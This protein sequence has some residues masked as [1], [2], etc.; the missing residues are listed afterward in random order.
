MVTVTRRTCKLRDIFRRSVSDSILQG[1]VILHSAVV[2]SCNLIQ[3]QRH[4][5]LAR[6]SVDL[7]SLL[8]TD[9]TLA[10]DFVLILELVVTTVRDLHQT[11][12]VTNQV[13]VDA[14]DRSQ[15]LQTRMVG[16]KSV[17]NVAFLR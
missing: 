5:C 13:C 10:V 8:A 7:A 6:I 16:R 3:T 1:S 17:K 2:S 11:L 12:S 15:T 9:G 14:H 4:R